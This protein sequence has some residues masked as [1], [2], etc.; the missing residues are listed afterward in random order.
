MTDARVFVDTLKSCELRLNSALEGVSIRG[1]SYFTLFSGGFENSIDSIFHRIFAASPPE[2]AAADL[3]SARELF[4]GFDRLS[5]SEKIEVLRLGA[6]RISA[7]ASQF[8]DAAPARPSAVS[9]VA[10]G[11]GDT[12][13]AIKGVGFSLSSLL[14]RKGVRTVWDA[15][16]YFP[17]RYEDRRNIKGISAAVPDSWQTVAGRVE[18][19]E[20][21]RRGAG[22]QF[23]VVLEESA[24]R[25]DLVWFHFDERYLRGIYR[26]GKLVLVSGD[27]GVDAR[28]GTLRILHPA[29]DGIEILDKGDEARDSPHINRVTP[30]Y[31]LTEGLGQRRLRGIMKNVIGLSAP[32]NRLLPSAVADG[33]IPLGEALCEM[34]FPEKMDGCPDFSRSAWEAGGR[35][36]DLPAPR[37]V[38]F[39]EF[40]LLQLAIGIGKNRRDGSGGIAFGREGDLSRRFIE[41]LPFKLTD[42][43][44][45]AFSRIRLKMES[46]HPMNMLLQGDV[47]SGKTVIALLAIMKAV[48]CGYQAALMAPTQILAEQHAKFISRHTEGFGLETVLLKGGD[49]GV[50][51]ESVEN[52]EARL[53]V[54]TH[55]LIQDKVKFKRLGLAVV[56]EQ[57][58]FGVA[59]REK[60][61]G[62]GVSPDILVMTATPIPRSLAMTVYGDLEVAT[63]DRLPPGRKRVETVVLGSSLKDRRKMIKAMSDEIGAGGQCYVV[64]P[65]IDRSTEDG[66]GETD[67]IARV[68]ETASNL[69][70][71]L[72]GARVSV[73]HGRMAAEEKESVMGGFLGGDTDVLVS[74]TVVEVGIDVP[75]ATLMA[76]ENADRFGLLQLHQLRGRV[77]RGKRDSVCIL[78]KSAEISA[79]GIRRLETLSGNSDGFSIAEADLAMRG[80]GEF[81]GTKQSGM[82]DFRFADLVMDAGVLAQARNAAAEFLEKDPDLKDHPELRERVLG[83]PA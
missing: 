7:I 55:A 76:V 29:A 63:V 81:L 42:A 73:L 64:C 40:F 33:L 12:V 46:P 27:I 53:V 82:P 2:K 9:G 71:E 5:D 17:L 28:R 23:R 30:V 10:G 19:A 47:G 21:T 26:K 52:G 15:L 31:P 32:A 20:R 35:D 43:Q 39:F 70:K 78:L 65:F 77:G 8:Q 24:A 80:P 62:K 14:A 50:R 49:S 69:R 57:H 41:G 60:L 66:E 1:G 22:A 37:T 13:N 56:D 48:D 54:G 44:R 25:L 38:A 58:K 83:F 75:N 34:H 36:R 6:G 4:R 18:S 72:P 59:Q 16:F 51:L 74:T 79:E 45:K 3:E 67:D 68:L 61:R 11:L